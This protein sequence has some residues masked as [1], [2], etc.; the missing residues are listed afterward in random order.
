MEFIDNTGHIFSLTSFDSYPTGY[1]Y[2]TFDYVFYLEDE[3]V[4]RLSV[5][6]FYIKPI[7]ALLHK[8]SGSLSSL[9]IKID[10][11]VFKLIGSKTIQQKTSQG[12]FNIEFNEQDESFKSELSLDDI[13]II[14]D[15]DDILIT[16]YVIGTADSPATWTS[17]ILIDAEYNGVHE[18]CPITVGGVF[19]DEQEELIIN[20][21]NMGVYF[22]KDIIKAVYGSSVYNDT[23]NE[24]LYNFKVKEYMMNYMKL[25]G[26]TG[27]L[28]HIKS[29]LKFFGWGDKVKL[30]Q[31][32]RTDNNIISQYIR[33]F[34]STE[35]DLLIR[36]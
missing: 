34:L 17:N 24:A 36:E 16:F 7:R 12:I 13:Y 3:Y 14:E 30:V 23:I 10:S 11:G 2:E 21:R 25:H 26:E 1:E 31:L 5:N 32:V 33:D 4:R 6:N 20:G 19:Y 9:S 15:D 8:D 35:N 29:S 18:Y 22:P 28:D 27:N